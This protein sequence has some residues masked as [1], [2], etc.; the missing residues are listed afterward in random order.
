MRSPAP[1]PPPPLQAAA[2]EGPAGSPAFLPAGSFRARAPQSLAFTP[3]ALVFFLFILPFVPQHGRFIRSHRPRSPARALLPTGLGG[4]GRPAALPAPLHPR[5]GGGGGSGAPRSDSFQ[6]G[7]GAGRMRPR[8]PPPSALLPAARAPRAV[9][10]EPPSLAF[11]N[12][13]ASRFNQLGPRGIRGVRG[14]WCWGS[15][16]T[17]Q[18]HPSYHQPTTCRGHPQGGGAGLAAAPPAPDSAA[19]LR[20]RAPTGNAPPGIQRPPC[21][22]SSPRGE[23]P[24]ASPQVVD[25]A[26]KTHCR[27]LV[28][29]GLWA[30]A[31][32]T[33]VVRT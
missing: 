13:P 24:R 22:C 19:A 4:A 26:Q 16:A 29:P 9:R 1:A 8:P 20:G 15:S 6:Y 30:G 17:S 25:G 28:S 14:L 31:K 2:R 12:P 23:G 5:S 33:A 3:L 11:P 21:P 10:V 18:P 32:L 7:T 27:P